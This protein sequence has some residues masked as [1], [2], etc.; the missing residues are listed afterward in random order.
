MPRQAIKLIG[1]VTFLI[2][3]TTALS[4]GESKL[5]TGGGSSQARLDFRITVP[6]ILFLQIG[7]AGATVD[8]IT[9]NVNNIPGTGAVEGSSSGVYPVPIRAAGFLP[10]GQR[11]SV[12]AN[13]S[14]PLTDGSENIRFDNIRWTATGNFTNGRFNNTANQLIRRWTNSGNRTGTMRFFYDNDE[15][16]GSGTYQGRVIYTLSSP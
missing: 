6:T 5:Q 10:Q 13:S 11:M 1:L 12:R 8:R 14:A 3:A 15:Y 9:F 16:H 7:T 2:L 4:W